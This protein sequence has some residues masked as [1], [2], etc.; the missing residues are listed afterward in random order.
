MASRSNTAS[1]RAGPN[2]HG[3]HR[4]DALALVETRCALCGGDDAV[5]E[6]WGYDFEYNTAQNPFRFVRCRRCAHRLPEPAPA[7]PP[8]SA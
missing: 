1:P 7:H 6:A 4:R 8:T 3:Q 5:D 2:P